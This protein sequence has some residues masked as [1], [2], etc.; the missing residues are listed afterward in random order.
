MSA[1][2]STLYNCL[3]RPEGLEMV[4]N[5]H[6]MWLVVY[7]TTMKNISAAV[8]KCSNRGWRC[9]SF[10]VDENREGIAMFKRRSP[11]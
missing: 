5:Q 7:P 10:G 6:G 8:S 4:V 9:Y 2:Y 11:L 1:L 3:G